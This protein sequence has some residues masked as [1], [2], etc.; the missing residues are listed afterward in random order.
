VISFPAVIM[1]NG[2]C[3]E[4][5]INSSFTGPSVSA[6]AFT[7]NIMAFIN[8]TIAFA[9]NAVTDI[10]VF[11][12]SAVLVASVLAFANDVIMSAY[13]AVLVASVLAFANNAM[14]LFTY[15]VMVFANRQWFP[16]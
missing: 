11:A 14:V 16:R 3:L 9:Y 7:Y 5:Y 2:A 12:Y 15:N 1:S 13:N 8:G 6:V 10:A 4:S